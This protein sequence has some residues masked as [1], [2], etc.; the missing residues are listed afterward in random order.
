MELNKRS[1][2]IIQYLIKKEE[3]VK[4]S[5]LANK[6]NVTN[7]TI[8]YDID[9]IE[10][11]FV[12]NGFGYLDRHHVKGV[13]IPKNKGIDKFLN[14][15][16]NTN[17]PFKYS[18]SKDERTKFIITKLLQASSPVKLN[19]FE[20]ILCVSRNT[21]LKEMD[22]IENWL[23]KKN[24]FLIRKPRVGIY[25]EG[26]EIEKRKA[27]IE[28][29]SE[30][31]STTDIFN[32]INRKMVQSKINNLQ[33][34]VLFSEVDVD[35][36]N[37]LV[38]EAEKELGKEFSDEAYGNLITHMA[39]MIKRI[40][41]N[42]NIYLPEV[43]LNMVKEYKEYDVSKKIISKIKD[44]Y[45][46]HVPAEETGYIALHL[47]GAKVLKTNHM[48]D[49]K[50]CK[51]DDL[52]D[53]V[54]KMTEE[55]E[56][57]YNVNFKNKKLKIIESLVLHL[58]PSI[59]RIKFGLKLENPLYDEI[60]TKYNT[61]FMNT[62]SVI[63]YL[64]EYIG[65]EVNNQEV[66]YI[67][68][69]YAAAFENVKKDLERKTRIILVCGTGIGTANMV[70]S[71]ISKEFNVEVVDTMSYRAVKNLNRKDYDYII[72]TIE[73]PD[74]NKEDYIKISPMLLKN[75][76][77][78]LE[79]YLQIKY[80]PKDGFNEYLVNR[81]INITEQ[82]CDIH[83]KQQ[84]QLE[85]LYELK[86]NRQNILER[87]VVYM[88]NDLLT[89][90]VIKLNVECSN[91]KE[92][93]KA[94]TNILLKKGCIKESYEKAIFTSFE[95]V[96][97]YMVVAPGIVLSHSRP[98][99][100]VDKLS[101]SLITLKEPIEFG[102]STND[103]VKL[104]ITLAAKDNESHLKALAQLMELFM[105]SDDLKKVMKASNKEELLKIINKYSKK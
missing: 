18:Y 76:Y 92:A 22:C 39:I 75:D 2:E 38:I 64:E 20:E 55:I 54:K 3:F 89:K 90:D 56:K 68:L 95:E 8:R 78:K 97:P 59:Y 6:Y 81:L 67:T 29:A 47:L 53:I 31:I 9:K 42:K 40:Q 74:C 101:M 84:L 5:E 4:V 28:V 58:R 24:L 11:I 35:F 51:Y 52:Y 41:L 88:L 37:D 10:K 12:K 1:I 36:L 103:P 32:Y 100:G 98:E 102:S 80:K 50:N 91:W 82:Y 63:R 43:D 46:I 69:H 44:K 85:F 21:I 94:G 71:Q 7:R 26:S 48:Y 23:F 72:S 25:I 66:S 99:N 30:T 70:A 14:K 15:F 96:G 62:K 60:I 34:E 57:I 16:V 19:Y 27:I 104:V 83:D 87:R 61:L 45:N 65:A 13:R 33:F 86:R 93:I 17:T 105:N 49:L 79:K 73:I 77:E